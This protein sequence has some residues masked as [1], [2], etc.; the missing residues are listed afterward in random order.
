MSELS[1][2]KVNSIAP[3]TSEDVAGD[4]KFDDEIPRLVVDAAPSGRRNKN[5]NVVPLPLVSRIC[6]SGD[7]SEDE[8]EEK[9][10]LE[11]L[12]AQENRLKVVASMNVIDGNSDSE[13]EEVKRKIE[14][15]EKDRLNILSALNAIGSRTE[16]VVRDVERRILKPH[17]VYLCDS[18]S[19]SDE[20]AAI[21]EVLQ[22]SEFL[23]LKGISL[24]KDATASE[25][26]IVAKAVI[27][28]EEGDAQKTKRD[29]GGDSD[30]YSDSDCDSDSTESEDDVPEADILEA[31][32]YMS[33][34][35][36]SLNDDTDTSQYV[37]IAKAIRR[38]S[39]DKR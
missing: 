38:L 5:K 1:K 8:D 35:G 16:T 19:D 22:A 30:R 18:D 17:R 7:E 15:L 37:N 33:L 6:S 26:V 29:Q 34:R 20:D 23:E 2:L 9:I 14:K 3:D 21:L 28:T 4:E 12:R 27:E 31:F 24:N 39:E 10:E 13:E 36:I 25:Y 11:M 32:R